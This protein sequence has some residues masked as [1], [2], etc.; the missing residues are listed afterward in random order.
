M[1]DAR[2][3]SPSAER[4]REPILAVLRDALPARGRVLEIASGTGEHAIWFAGAL[5]GLDWQP[6]DAD[7]EAR[8]S[9]AAWT[10]HA[11]LANVRAPLALDV[12]QPDWG[13]DA[14]DAVVCINMIH[15][16]PWS[17]AQALIDGAGRRLVDGGVLYLYGPYRRGG[18][19]TAPSNEAFEQWLKS[20]NPD[21][22]VRDM[23]AV[24]ALGDAA[25]LTCE[26]V[27]AMPANNFSLVF[28]KR[29]G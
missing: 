28:R 6:S 3:H 17:A 13:V 18:A 19:H 23:E 8:E 12:H 25:G 21:W 11:G 7:E 27:V 4:N 15:I 14:L 24:V 2:Q 9:I 1:T 16:S 26:R 10:A 29:A 22:G 20:R 5:P